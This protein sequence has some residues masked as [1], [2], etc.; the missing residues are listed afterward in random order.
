MAK[1]IL[2]RRE[3]RKQAD[4]A[5]QTAPLETEEAPVSAPAPKGSKTKA[6]AAA[7]PRA[8]KPRKKKEPAR[9]CARWGVF[10][11]GMKQIA[12]FDYNNRVAAEEKV[13]DLRAKKNAVYFIQMV[14]E[15]MPEPPPAA[16][17]LA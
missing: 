5:E 12:I 1:R 13:A 3:L 16:A 14:K 11:T 10:D 9:L 8:A 7:K 15:P 17:P 4:Q 2:N 6:K